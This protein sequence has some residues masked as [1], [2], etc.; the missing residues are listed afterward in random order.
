MSA[1]RLT[2]ALTAAL[3]T[4]AAVLTVTPA[5]AMAPDDCAPGKICAWSEMFYRGKM[6]VLPAGAGCVNTE[7]PVYSMYNTYG[8]PGIPAVALMYT[9]RNCTGTLLFNVGPKER[10][11]AF[12]A[13]ALSAMLAW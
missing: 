4:G 11:P 1:R 6:A 10:Y 13:P 7:F 9:G 12:P 8:T 2:Q 5:N 3:I